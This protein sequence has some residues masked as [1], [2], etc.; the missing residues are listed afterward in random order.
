MRKKLKDMTPF[1][2]VEQRL[3]GLSNEEAEDVA[4]QIIA[5]VAAKRVHIF[6]DEEYFGKLGR[7]LI[8]ATAKYAKQHSFELALG[9][10]IEKH[11]DK[12]TKLVNKEELTKLTETI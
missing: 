9:S 12:L 3:K 4:V 6:K 2:R 8:E 11:K 7:K 10:A 1:E 5:Q